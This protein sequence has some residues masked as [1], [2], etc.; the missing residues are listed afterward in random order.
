M[1]ESPDTLKNTGLL[2]VQIFTW[3]FHLIL[4]IKMVIV[5]IMHI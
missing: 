5:V 1:Q 4:T 3:R 2:H